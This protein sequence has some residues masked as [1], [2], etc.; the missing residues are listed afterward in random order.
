[1]QDLAVLFLIYF[2]G[3]G[4]SYVASFSFT[5]GPGL[6]GGWHGLPA[7]PHQLGGAGG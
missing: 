6:Q 3:D 5:Q 7:L 4:N 2:C 1:M